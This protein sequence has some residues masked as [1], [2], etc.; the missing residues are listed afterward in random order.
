MTNASDILISDA[1]QFNCRIY[2]GKICI[3]KTR[4][5]YEGLMLRT[6]Q[7]QISDQ[8]FS[9]V[10]SWKGAV[11]LICL[12]DIDLWTYGRLQGIQK[13]RPRHLFK[14]AEHKNKAHCIRKLV[15]TL[16]SY[17]AVQWRYSLFVN[18][19]SKFDEN[20]LRKLDEIFVNFRLEGL[21]GSTRI[22][23]IL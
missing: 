2:F 10:S 16:S 20:K 18:N 7:I 1:Q 12:G 15:Q 13:A 3:H 22:L 11:F 8:A 17:S 4:T 19:S 9:H 14:R 23:L 5:N 6:R 21:E